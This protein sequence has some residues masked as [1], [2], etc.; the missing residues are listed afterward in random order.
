MIYTIIPSST[1]MITDN[2]P[3][4]VLKSLITINLSKYFISLTPKRHAAIWVVKCF[5]FLTVCK[6]FRFLPKISDYDVSNCMQERHIIKSGCPDVLVIWTKSRH[7]IATDIKSLKRIKEL[8]GCLGLMVHWFEI[9]LIVHYFIFRSN[10]TELQG[11]QL[12]TLVG[13]VIRLQ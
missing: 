1:C 2:F 8:V 10:C 7:I 13:R 4:D 9:K 6:K 11:W 5:M 3:N 12:Q